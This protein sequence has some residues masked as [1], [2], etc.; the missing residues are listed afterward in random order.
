MALCTGLVL[1]TAAAQPF[2]P[3]VAGVH[4]ESHPV[5][6]HHSNSHRGCRLLH[7][8]GVTPHWRGCY[9]AH[10][11]NYST[12]AGAAKLTAGAGNIF[13]ITG[14]GVAHSIGAGAAQLTAAAVLTYSTTEAGAAYTA[15]SGVMHSTTGA[16]AAFPTAGTGEMCSS[17]SMYC[18]CWRSMAHSR[19]R[20]DVLY[21]GGWRKILCGS[22]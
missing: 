10:W 17:T 13:S 21:R 16:G 2:L 8:C 7:W 5:K 11:K 12:G 20:T 18:R 6:N 1:Q 4:L 19:S 15:G 3:K 22:W 14:A 9:P